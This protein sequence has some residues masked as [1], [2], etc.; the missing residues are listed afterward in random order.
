MRCLIQRVKEASV[1]V[2][3]R[4]IS[5]I[6]KGLLVFLGISKEDTQKEIDFLV[7]KLVYLR[8]FPDDT[9][10]MNLDIK[11]V[12]GEILVVSQFTLYGDCKKGRRPSFDQAASPE[13]ARHLYHSFLSSLRDLFSGVKSGEFQAMMDV[14]LVNDGPVT[15]SL[16]C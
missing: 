11:E 8:L 2:D 5:S 1:V 14:S 6:N 4:V 12:S 3:G 13:V 16:E 10:K 9:G 15:V 7:N